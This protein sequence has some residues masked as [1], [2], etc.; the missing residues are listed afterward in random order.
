MTLHFAFATRNL[1]L[2]IFVLYKFTELSQIN[3]FQREDA[4]MQSFTM[5]PT[6]IREI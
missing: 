2:N 4:G 6:P 5:V 3:P 1:L